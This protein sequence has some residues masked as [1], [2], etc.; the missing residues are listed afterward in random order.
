MEMLH[1]LRLSFAVRC[2]VTP[3]SRCHRGAP[4]IDQ[5]IGLLS[6]VMRAVALAHGFDA[7]RLALFC[8]QRIPTLLRF[9]HAGSLV[10]IIMVNNEYSCSPRAT[11]AI[12][13]AGNSH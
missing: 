13:C 8:S 12:R 1:C 2:A 11:W 10:R 5:R 9:N 4:W 3:S 6:S 7:R